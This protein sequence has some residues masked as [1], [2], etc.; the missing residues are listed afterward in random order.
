MKGVDAGGVGVEDHASVVVHGVVVG[1]GAGGQ[2]EAAHE[3]V[4]L[5]RAVADGLGPASSTAEP[6]VL[7]VP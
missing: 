6:V 3:L 1:F 2:T 4:L 5:Q 7:H